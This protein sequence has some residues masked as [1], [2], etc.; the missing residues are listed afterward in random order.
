MEKFQP[1]NRTF[2][3]RFSVTRGQGPEEHRG[4]TRV[5]P[6]GVQSRKS[7]GVNI[8]CVLGS[9]Q[10]QFDRSQVL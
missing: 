10:L 9:A 4:L 8:S 5:S 1:A 2:S 7:Q 6:R 3:G